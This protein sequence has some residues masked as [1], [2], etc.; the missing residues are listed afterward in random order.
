MHLMLS[1]RRGALG[2]PGDPGLPHGFDAR[3]ERAEAGAEAEAAPESEW[4][5]RAPLAREPPGAAAPALLSAALAPNAAKASGGGA[6][7]RTP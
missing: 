6:L 2:A 4:P 1:E 7:A 3:E 5:A